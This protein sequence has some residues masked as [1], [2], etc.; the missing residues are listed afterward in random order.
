MKTVILSKLDFMRIMDCIKEGRRNNSIT[1]QEA[2]SLL[3]ELR[4][5]EVVDPHEVPA[6]IVTM[7]T[8]VKFS[9]LNTNKTVVF[10]I[11]YPDKANIKENKVSI[12]S[13]IATA[14][15]GYKVGD[16]IE[17]MTPA[18]LTRIRIDEIIFQP[19][20]AGQYYV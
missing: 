20:A 4:S 8:V 16:E 9:F 6:D 10:Q 2:D 5:A 1:I 15:I 17:W 3:K 7:N 12:F 19:E 13:S 11:V 14:L 18:G